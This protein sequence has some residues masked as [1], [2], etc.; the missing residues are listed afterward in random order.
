MRSVPLS[1]S[2]ETPGET[3]LGE[4]EIGMLEGFEKVIMILKLRDIW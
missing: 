3:G 1:D 4:C 2:T